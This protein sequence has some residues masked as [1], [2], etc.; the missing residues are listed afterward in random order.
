MYTDISARIR[1]VAKERVSIGTQTLF[2][3]LD[4]AMGPENVRERAAQIPVHPAA[5]ETRR[6]GSQLP[7]G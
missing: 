2:S 3:H 6:T 1:L 4:G 5:G 7:D